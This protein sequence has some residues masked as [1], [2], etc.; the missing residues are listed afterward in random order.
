MTENELWRI[1]MKTGRVS[2]YIKYMNVR[3]L[4][5]RLSPYGNDY[6]SELAEEFINN[7][8]SDF[9]EMQSDCQ[10]DGSNDD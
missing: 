9:P 6:S 7:F 1:F 10:E 8:D 3:D 5:E 2:D 4:S